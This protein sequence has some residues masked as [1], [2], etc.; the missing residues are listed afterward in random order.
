MKVQILL[1]ANHF[2]EWGIFYGW[3]KRY[4]YI[5]F[6]VTKN[7]CVTLYL[8]WIEINFHGTGTPLNPHGSIYWYPQFY[9]EPHKT[10]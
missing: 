7:G 6:D 3:N 1:D 10:K 2:Q 4:G 8:T 9:L 5:G